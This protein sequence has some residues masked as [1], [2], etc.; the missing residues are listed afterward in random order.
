[1]HTQKENQ[2][3][4]NGQNDPFAGFASNETVSDT[5]KTGRK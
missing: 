4:V 3:H 1:M 5:H 2:A